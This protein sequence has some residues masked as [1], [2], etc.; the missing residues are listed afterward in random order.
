MVTAKIQVLQGF[1][2]SAERKIL[3]FIDFFRVR[4]CTVLGAVL[5][6]SVR[7]LLELP[8]E[9]EKAASQRCYAE[10]VSKVSETSAFCIITLI[11]RYINLVIYV[12]AQI[13]LAHRTLILIYGLVFTIMK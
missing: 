9:I 6:Q 8:S 11:S 1:F 3:V 5:T 12:F 7:T 2:E 4:K 13:I 10:F